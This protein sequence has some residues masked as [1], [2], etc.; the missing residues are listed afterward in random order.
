[1]GIKI[2]GFEGSEAL[3]KALTV[4]AGASLGAVVRDTLTSMY[5]RSK[6]S[7]PD[8]GGTPFITG[9]LQA[10][11]A[12]TEDRV[13]YVKEYAPHVEYG[14]RTKSGS[15]VPGRRYLQRNVDIEKPLYIA[16]L[17]Q[18]MAKLLKGK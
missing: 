2:D 17:N 16:R 18:A 11:I 12:V 6:T 13:M 4:D 8:M 5:N 14:H 9:E 3:E 1:M 7:N 15:V 10:S